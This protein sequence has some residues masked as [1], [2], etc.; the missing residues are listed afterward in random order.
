MIKWVQI[1][2]CKKKKKICVVPDSDYLKFV[3]QVMYLW[4]GKDCNEVFIKDV[5]GCPDYTS[6]PASMVRMICMFER[7]IMFLA[8]QHTAIVLLT[9]YRQWDVLCRRAKNK[10]IKAWKRTGRLRC[11]YMCVIGN[12]PK[13]LSWTQRPLRE[14]ELLCPGFRNPEDFVLPSTCSSKTPARF[15]FSCILCLSAPCASS[16]EVLSVHSLW[17][18]I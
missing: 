14:L 9:D 7:Q 4:L 11:V 6:I 15:F 8:I 13:F 10:F 3:L 12:R 17:K 16:I 18:D 1:C 2:L 5:L